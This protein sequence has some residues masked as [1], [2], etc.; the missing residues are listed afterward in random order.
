MVKKKPKNEDQISSPEESA[1]DE[2]IVDELP[3]QKILLKYGNPRKAVSAEVN[4]K[5]SFVEDLSIYKK[6]QEQ[7]ERINKR[8]A[9]IFMFSN[10]DDK[11]KEQI[12]NYMQ[13]KKYKQG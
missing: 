10:L 7:K 12:I 6:K 13:E 9:Q 1:D 11:E 5:P 3:V 2:E 4:N 8:L